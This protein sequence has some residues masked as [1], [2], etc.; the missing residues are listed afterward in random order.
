MSR[1]IKRTSFDANVYDAFEFELSEWNRSP[2][3]A[4]IPPA[5][6]QG[7]LWAN[8]QACQNYKD[9]KKEIY[10]GYT[11]RPYPIIPSWLTVEKTTD[12]G[13][14]SSA[15]ENFDTLTLDQ[16]GT[17]I[18]SGTLNYRNPD[19]G[20]NP[21]DLYPAI[22]YFFTESDDTDNINF[23]PITDNDAYYDTFYARNPRLQ[24]LTGSISER[25][26]A[27]FYDVFTV[28]AKTGGKTQLKISSSYD[29]DTLTN[30]AYFGDKTDGYNT[31]TFK[32][33]RISS[34]PDPAWHKYI[35]DFA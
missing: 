16:E 23:G 15:L 4:T 30:N 33:E 22:F 7:H 18:I 28:D 26:C 25:F 29:G 5:I 31:T 3:D 32:I 19:L 11:N 1:T 13:H 10:E 20:T 24:N 9:Y 21:D 17:Y 2:D 6:N 34:K 35:T 27:D 8:F 12:V 14:S